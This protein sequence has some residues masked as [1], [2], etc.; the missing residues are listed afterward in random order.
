MP[1]SGYV[2][3]YTHTYIPYIHAYMQTYID[4]YTQ[5]YIGLSAPLT[6]FMRKHVLSHCFSAPESYKARQPTDMQTHKGKTHCAY[7]ESTYLF[8]RTILNMDQEAK[9]GR[10]LLG[11]ETCNPNRSTAHTHCSEPQT[12][13]SVRPEPRSSRCAYV[14]RGA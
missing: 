6:A 8:V 12:E 11:R 5:T 14:E 7:M 10:L 13:W 3:T 9:L 4:S 2:R 1:C